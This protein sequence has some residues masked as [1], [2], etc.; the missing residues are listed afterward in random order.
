LPGGKIKVVQMHRMILGLESGD[1]RQSDHK[2]H[3]G[4]NNK[5]NN[6][7]VCTHAQN[8]Q[9]RKPRKNGSSVFK[10]VS[11]H[12]KSKKWRACIQIDGRTVHLGLFRSET[13]AATAYDEVANTIHGEF[14]LLNL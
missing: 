11:W 7:R 4:L 9:N 3:N 2:D 6:L 12:K 10:G 5:R 1:K 13:E 14:A 8:Q